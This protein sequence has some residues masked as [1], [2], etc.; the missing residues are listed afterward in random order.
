MSDFKKM[1]P[2]VTR[3]FCQTMALKISGHEK[4]EKNYQHRHG[5]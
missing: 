1:F 3:Q 4:T 5:I 2:K